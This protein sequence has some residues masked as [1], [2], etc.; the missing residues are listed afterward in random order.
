MQKVNFSE[1]HSLVLLF[2]MGRTKWDIVFHVSFMK[3]IVP[4]VTFTAKVIN[5]IHEVTHHNEKTHILKEGHSTYSTYTDCFYITEGL[6]VV[7]THNRTITMTL[8]GCFVNQQP[9]L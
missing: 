8:F 2:I 7:S 9:S 5:L 6:H 4:N 3:W 1:Q